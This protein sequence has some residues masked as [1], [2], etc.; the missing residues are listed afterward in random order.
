MP[1]C[2]LPDPNQNDTD[3]ELMMH[4]QMTGIHRAWET[5]GLCF[6]SDRKSQMINSAQRQVARDGDIVGVQTVEGR[7]E[8]RP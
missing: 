4:V 6:A 5:R 8:P 3:L 1:I 7:G 2:P